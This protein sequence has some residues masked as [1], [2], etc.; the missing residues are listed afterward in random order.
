MYILFVFLVLENI[1]ENY[2]PQMRHFD[3]AITI[4]FLVLTVISFSRSKYHKKRYLKIYMYWVL[5]VSIGLLSTFCY[6]I[7]ENT[8]VILKDILAVSKF[9]IVYVYASEYIKVKNPKSV[10]KKTQNFSKIYLII[11]FCFA[12]INQIMNIGMDSG[13]RGI[14]KTYMFLYTHTTFMAAS[15]IIVSTVLIAGGLKKNKFYVIIA[16]VILASSMRIKALIYIVSVLFLILIVRG[17]VVTKFHSVWTKK[18]KRKIGIA[19]ITISIVAYFLAK[20]KIADYMAWGLVAARPALYIVGFRILKDYFPMGSGFG[21]FASSLSGE[22]YSPLYSKYGIQ[23]TSGLMKAEGYPYMA[24]TYWPYV[25]A[26]FGAFGMLFYI[27]GLYEIVK[28][29][30]RYSKKNMDG[31]IAVVA[32]L[33]YLIG[34]SFVEAMFTNSPIVLIA[35]TLG[36]YARIQ[37]ENTEKGD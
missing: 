20:D 2:I 13:Y 5:I 8:V 29:V 34:S 11:L 32:L 37:C 12:L 36:F 3:E 9:F 7:Q 33:I 25:Y 30:I 4:V 24:D 28:D 19:G 1:I 16:M 6:Q 21:T 23:N 35:L 18:T 10:L 31:M 15:V 26:Q 22:Y 27:L 14:V 17:N